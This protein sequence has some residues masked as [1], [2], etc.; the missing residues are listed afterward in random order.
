MTSV[1]LTYTG[2][3]ASRHDAENRL[4]KRVPRI[5]LTPKTA[6][7]VEAQVQEDD[8]HLLE[9]DPDWH[10]SRPA[11]LGIR[12]PSVI[13]G[14]AVTFDPQRDDTPFYIRPPANRTPKGSAAAIPGGRMSFLPQSLHSPIRR[15]DR[16]DAHVAIQ[17][18][19]DDSGKLPRPL[20]PA[21]LTQLLGFVD[22]SPLQGLIAID[23]SP[24]S[25]VGNYSAAA[26][27]DGVLRSIQIAVVAHG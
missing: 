14:G 11:M 5:V 24:I 27:I 17:I 2:K 1:V 6:I 15:I 26:M 18:D 12:Q 13:T 9:Q 21:E 4:R 23:D 10:V 16:F 3:P 8:L 7:L 25:G 19:C 22:V 20:S